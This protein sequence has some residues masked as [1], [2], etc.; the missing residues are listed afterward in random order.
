MNSNFNLNVLEENKLADLREFAQELGVKNT[1]SMRKAEVIAEIMLALRAE[2][3]KQLAAQ[4][5]EGP[6]AQEAQG[7][8]P[9]RRGRKTTAQ[10]A[11]ERNAK[12]AGKKEEID[13]R[14]AQVEKTLADQGV[15]IF[16]EEE[17]AEKKGAP[18]SKKQAG[19]GASKRKIPYI[20]V[21]KMNVE[22]LDKSVLDT[23]SDT[24]SKEE[25]EKI[26]DK[27]IREAFVIDEKDIAAV[28]EINVRDD[29]PEADALANTPEEKAP[30]G[31][32]KGEGK[33]GAKK[34]KPK[35]DTQIG[36]D[37]APAAP[38][39]EEKQEEKA[40]N[41]VQDT[42]PAEEKQEAKPEP[43]L[44][45]VCGIL[46]FAPENSFGFLRTNN[47]YSGA[48]DVYVSLNVMRRMGLRPGDRIEGGARYMKDTDKFPALNQVRAINGVPFEEVGERK[49]FDT[50]IPIFPN[51]RI[52]L[53]I[54]GKN[55]ELATRLI[56]LIAPIGKGQRGLIVS[57]PKAGKTVLLKKIANSI[58]QNHPDV[59]LII[60]LIDERPE[61][62]TDMQR[63]TTGE[64]VYS[65]FDELPEH[66]TRISENVLEHSKRLVEMGKDVVIL[67]DSITRLARAY[68][69]T[70][71]VTGRTL[72]GGLD[73]SAL[74]KPKKFFG[75]AR[76]I[77]DGG[78]LTIIAT[79]LIET[80]SRMDDV[81]FEE[82]KGTGNMELHL[83]RKLS[84]KRIFPAIDINR[85]STRREDLLLSKRELDGVELMRKN[86]SEGRTERVTEM[87]INTLTK[88]ASNEK[89]IAAMREGFK[90]S[91]KEQREA[92]IDGL[93]DF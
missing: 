83:D 48:S 25:T 4:R 11:R 57:P 53:E 5:A 17:K 75:A 38:A 18:V 34:E 8:E 79:A 37:K 22:D 69:L 3:E 41:A 36:E 73:P 54:K 12:G 23:F 47:F 88:T 59:H 90:K 49:R 58:T 84:E 20:A 56:D 9:I 77:E 45:P 55:E 14:I 92:S 33:K 44:I 31:R 81:I 42:P 78:S 6:T 72:S 40:D 1:A 50:L 30:T 7:G 87:I 91:E 24:P 65:T 66:H 85:S 70:V 28:R 13:E 35:K 26:E 10:K 89:F 29:S 15:I 60:L 67:L 2:S 51:E 39:E 86:F 74:F 19:E 76:N 52:N 64:V 16:Q 61:E 68:N 93:F 71:P 32:A 82:F 21:P 43:E 63:S 62:V 46:E 27:D 80:G